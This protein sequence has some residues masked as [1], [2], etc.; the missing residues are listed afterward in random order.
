M[1]STISTTGGL[2]GNAELPPQDSPH[3]HKVSPVQHSERRSAADT[4]PWILRR[5]WLMERLARAPLGMPESGQSDLRTDYLGWSQLSGNAARDD[6]K[7]F[8]AH[9]DVVHIATGPRA[10]WIIHR[11]RLA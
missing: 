1:E 5:A 4:P 2:G 11:S 9:P 3:T 6:W 8:L 7:R 10:G